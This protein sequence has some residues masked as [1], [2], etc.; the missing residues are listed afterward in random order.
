MTFGEKKNYLIY[1]KSKILK[2]FFLVDDVVDS[3]FLTFS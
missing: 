2:L 3:V 1:K